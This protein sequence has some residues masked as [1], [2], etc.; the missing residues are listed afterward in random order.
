[1]IPKEY[2]GLGFSCAAHSAVLEKITTRSV[3]VCTYVMVP[4]SLGPAELLVHYGTTAQKD[5]YLNR[6]ATGQDI[7]CFGLTEPQAGSDAGAIESEGILFK[8]EKGELKIKL[9]WNKRWIT[10]AGI[11]TLI[12]LAFKLKDPNNLLG[13]GKIDIGITCGLVAANLKGIDLSRRHDPLGLPFHNC[14]MTGKDV[15]VNAETCIIGGLKGAGQGWKMLIESLGAGRGISLPSQAS[16]ASKMAA[17]VTSNHS[18]I[19]NQFGTS[20]KNFEGIQEALARITA[21]TYYIDSLRQFVLDALNQNKK[22]AVVTA[23]AKYHAT[24]S[25]R[26]NMIDAMSI[27]GGAGISL[28]PRNLLGIG[29]MG[30]PICITVEGAN[31][32]TRTLMIF[33]Q[34]ALRS[35]PFAFKEINAIKNNKVKDFDNAIF[36][37][38]YHFVSNC[39]RLIILNL[40]R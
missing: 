39:C 27:L 9:N 32:L 18:I 36:G 13:T 10:L 19:R 30:F 1:C 22:P 34:G 21:R 23:I 20:I 6:L 29:Y 26:D 15:I 38:F 8:D 31:I 5:K 24:E 17:R 33:G 35:H 3:V 11:A 4:N 40:S 12:G 16:S 7:P 14:P 28:G 2:G 25:G 37:H